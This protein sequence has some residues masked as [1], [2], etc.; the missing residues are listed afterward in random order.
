[1]VEE[2]VSKDDNDSSMEEENDSSDTED[3]DTEVKGNP[4]LAD[5]L[6]K[7]IRMSK[8]K[9][10]KSIVL[11]KAKL[12]SPNEEN[13]NK[14]SDF[15]IEPNPNVK[16]KV[17]DDA[18]NGSEYSDTKKDIKLMKKRALKKQERIHRGRLKPS[19]LDRDK[20]RPLMKIATRG[21]VRL[22]NAVQQQQSNINREIN[23]PGVTEGKK[24]KVLQSINKATFLDVLRGKQSSKS[25][26]NVE[27]PQHTDDEIKE[28][29]DDETESSW[30]VLRDDF[31]MG[32]KL[33]DWDKN[34]IAVEEQY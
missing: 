23:K 2:I 6:A 10:G 8:N 12:Y 15:D 27:S 28:E 33:K 22:F 9:K 17:E 30:Q 24:E 7:V 13:K 1:M 25:N 26:H 4:G 18:Q 3:H 19:V 11:S 29:P 34:D 20:E 32:A 31:M 16:I 5:A 14:K 21:V